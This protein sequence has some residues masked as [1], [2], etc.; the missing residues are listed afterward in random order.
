MQFSCSVKIQIYIPE[1]RM[2]GQSRVQIQA[3]SW[4]LVGNTDPLTWTTS[5]IHCYRLCHIFPPSNLFR[6]KLIVENN[7]QLS[8]LCFF[9]SLLKYCG[10]LDTLTVSKPWNYPNAKWY[11]RHRLQLGSLWNHPFKMT[12]NDPV[13]V[14]TIFNI[15]S[16][17]VV[18]NEIYA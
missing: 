5:Q 12:L 13:A 17:V 15:P 6:I 2:S 3:A 7:H 4:R 9:T 8:F 1:H 11:V 14:C 18:Q 16:T 10:G